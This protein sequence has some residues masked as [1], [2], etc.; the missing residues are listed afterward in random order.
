MPFQVPAGHWIFQAAPSASVPVTVV[1]DP[2]PP[3]VCVEAEV[4]AGQASPPT[5]SAAANAMAP[6]LL[7]L[8]TITLHC[9]D[10]CDE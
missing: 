10:K 9:K 4:A 2:V 5:V 7:P 1:T 3:H 6:S 8:F